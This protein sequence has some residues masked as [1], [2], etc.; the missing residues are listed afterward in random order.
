MRR[1]KNAVSQIVPKE[2][3]AGGH[4]LKHAVLVLDNADIT[5]LFL[6]QNI[7]K[8]GNEDW[9]GGTA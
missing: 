9:D 1:V 8:S 4:S 3:K 5:A 6:G 7:G 2:V